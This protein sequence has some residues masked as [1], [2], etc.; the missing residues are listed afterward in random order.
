MPLHRRPRPVGRQVE[1]R[2]RAG[3]V[4]APP[5][6]LPLELH[7]GEPAPL[8]D[9]EVGVLHRQGREIRRPTGESGP[10][11]GREIAHEDPQR[12]AVRDDVVQGEQEG[13]LLPGGR[14]PQQSGA[15]QRTLDEVEGARR[16]VGPQPPGRGLASGGRQ[17]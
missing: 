11:E 1:E 15:H 5:G 3:Q 4:L 8:P 10:I 13:V 14:Q 9:G 2:G 6:E 16:L 7:S 12:P 17:P